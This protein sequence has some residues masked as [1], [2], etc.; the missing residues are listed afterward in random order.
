[1]SA[2]APLPELTAA[3]VPVSDPR[4][5]PLLRELGDEYSARRG[6]ARKAVA[7]L[8]REA[9]TRGYRRLCLTTRPRR[10]EAPSLYLAT[11]YPLFDT[12]A[13]PESIGPLPF[14]KHLPAPARSGRAADL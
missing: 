9:T 12:G 8:Q 5:E 13:D 10:P 3:H 4:V 11:S 14:E 1:M 6:L 2:P 7:E